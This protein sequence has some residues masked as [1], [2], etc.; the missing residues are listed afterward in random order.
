MATHQ[1]EEKNLLE[2]NYEKTT[3]QGIYNMQK[4]LDFIRSSKVLIQFFAGHFGINNVE[5]Y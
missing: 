2:I 1:V 4:N 3:K 5:F